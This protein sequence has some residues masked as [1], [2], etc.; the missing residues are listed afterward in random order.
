[1]KKPIK[2]QL[3]RHA[4]ILIEINGKKIL[5]DPMLSEKDALDPVQN[6][7]NDIRFPM[8]EL[9]LSDSELRQ[10]LDKID[11]VFVT[12]LHR[13][14][15]DIAAQNLIDKNKAIF[16][17]INDK[18][19][20]NS[21]GFTNVCEIDNKVDWEGIVISRCSGQHGSGEIGLK[22][23]QVSGFVF[24]FDNQSI[25][26]A[27]DTI[28]C[29]EVEEAIETF[30]PNIIV[31]NAG[32]A[33]F[34]IGSAITMNA[35]DILRTYNKAVESKIIAVHMDTVNHCF[36]KRSDLFKFLKAQ[37]LENKVLIPQ[38]GEVLEF[39]DNI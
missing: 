21:Q 17:Q 33:Q 13:D 11:A 8:Q 15:W 2:I 22:M 27:G 23:G 7:G 39:G 1:M 20:L 35:E 38:D 12:H 25:Y 29:K 5:L 6:C 26:V 28:Y 24:T 18:V 32:A 36:L 16:C 34:L 37:N 10:L 19:A 9:P 14:H 3:L 30:N 4:T 31:V